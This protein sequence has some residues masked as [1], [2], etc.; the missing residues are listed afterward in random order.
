MLSSLL[1]CPGNYRDCVFEFNVKL[2]LASPSN[3]LAAVAPP[4]IAVAAEQGDNADIG[5]GFTSSD[6]IGAGATSCC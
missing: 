5:G 6:I 3:G 4:V 2:A 1:T